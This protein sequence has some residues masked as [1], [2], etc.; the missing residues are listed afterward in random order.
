MYC[1][2]IVNRNRHNFLSFVVWFLLQEDK[3]VNGYIICF[4][5]CFILSFVTL[6]CYL[7]ECFTKGELLEKTIEKARKSKIK[8][9]VKLSRNWKRKVVF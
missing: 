8:K 5:F 9:E 6:G 3:E 1:I 7:R 4:D 2:Y